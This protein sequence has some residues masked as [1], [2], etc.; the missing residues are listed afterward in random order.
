[1]AKPEYIAYS[2]FFPGSDT[3]PERHFEMANLCLSGKEYCRSNFFLVYM[4]T[5]PLEREW[6][7]HQRDIFEFYR[8]PFPDL[9]FHA[10][11]TS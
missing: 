8:L 5:M 9:C 6:H 2:E 7:C 3:L 1:M 11:F 4:T 10:C